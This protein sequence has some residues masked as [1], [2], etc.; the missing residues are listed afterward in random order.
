M[1]RCPYCMEGSAILTFDRDINQT[2]AALVPDK[3]KHHTLGV[4]GIPEG[5]RF[6]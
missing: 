3:G 1:I 6:Y 5:F 4:I 2:V